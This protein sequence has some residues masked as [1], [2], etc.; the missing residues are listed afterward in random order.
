MDNVIILIPALSP[1]KKIFY[2]YIEELLDNNFTNIIVVDDGSDSTYKIFYKELEDI[3][4]DVFYH[5]KNL[6]KGRALKNAFNYILSKYK[7]GIDY[8]ITVDSDGQHKVEDVKNIANIALSNNQKA[9]YLGSRDFDKYNVPFK[10]FFG[11]K[12]TSFVYR[13]LYSDNLKDTQTGLRAIPFEFLKD[14]LDLYGERF[15]YEINMLINCSINNKNIIEI[16]I[17]TVYFYD[18]KE[19]HFNPFLDSY[20][21]YKVMLKTFIK[22]TLSSLLSFLVDVGIFT[23]FFKSFSKFIYSST[24][25]IWIS[26]FLSRVLSGVFNYTINKNFVFNK[27]SR[28][29]MFKEY[30]ILWFIQLVLSGFL[31]TFVYSK[32]PFNPALIKILVDTLISIVSFNIQN[33]YIF[34]GEEK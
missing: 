12:L 1:P 34:N 22:F 23:L 17:Q 20:K 30:A 25:T 19:T 3:G 27:V 13:V 33:K 2:Q 6:G 26:T 21:I 32:I 29:G 4:I 11:N 31:V 8:I 9:L 28:E 7:T 18:N 16:P 10:S 5:N 24:L 15:E 14:F